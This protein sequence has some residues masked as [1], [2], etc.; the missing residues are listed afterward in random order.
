MRIS[1]INMAYRSQ[2]CRPQKQNNNQ[3]QNISFGIYE[4]PQVKQHHRD[5]LIKEIDTMGSFFRDE[6]IAEADGYI[7]YLDKADTITV[8]EKYDI[9]YATANPEVIN[10]GKHQTGYKTLVKD[11]KCHC[12]RTSGEAVI[13]E[14]EPNFLDFLRNS[15]RTSI[16]CKELI[17]TENGKYDDDYVP[18]KKEKPKQDDSVEFF[19][20]K[21]KLPFQLW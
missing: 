17:K 5:L 7:D 3:K 6:D 13:K 11:C 10:K 19:D 4:S 2:N 9:I 8:K 15:K 14:S 12:P 20:P 21:E 1:P 16:L 18:P